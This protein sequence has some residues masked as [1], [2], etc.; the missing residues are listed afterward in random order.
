MERFVKNLGK[1]SI[2]FLIIISSMLAGC[3]PATKGDTNIHSNECMNRFS[4]I[5]K[6]QSNILK[7]A[8][9]FSPE[10]TEFITNTVSL[11]AY[12]EISI[13][14]T[15]TFEGDTYYYNGFKSF[16]DYRAIK[17]KSSFQYAF[18]DECYTD[19]LGFRRQNDTNKYVVAVGTSVT[20][21]IGTD[22]ELVLEDGSIIS[23][24]VGDI[25]NN[26]HTDDGNLIT[27]VDS[28]NPC[29]SEF[30]VNEDLLPSQV[31]NSGDC[32]FVVGSSKINSIRIYI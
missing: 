2:V 15:V 29:A 16:M 23:C 19:D 22:I 28:K 30:L 17:N 26:A 7:D 32:S 13:P 24:V 25:K 21:K 18:Q 14:D 31:L 5:T 1:Q 6:V 8:L 20:D 3:S 10:I 27:C 12:E 4:G 11:P 9:A